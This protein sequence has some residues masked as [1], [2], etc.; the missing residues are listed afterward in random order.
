MVAQSVNH[1]TVCQVL[2]DLIKIKK[3]VPKEDALVL[4][5]DVMAVN[6]EMLQEIAKEMQ[7]LPEQNLIE[8]I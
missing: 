1:M 6:H 2:E 3:A 4:T 8:E 7:T 5:H